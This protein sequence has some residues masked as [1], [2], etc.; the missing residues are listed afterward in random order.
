MAAKKS[1]QKM[2]SCKRLFQAK[3]VK[4]EVL[5]AYE[6]KSSTCAVTRENSKLIILESLS[7]ATIVVTSG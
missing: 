7:N 5:G 1:V 6:V 2:P 3:E 4:R